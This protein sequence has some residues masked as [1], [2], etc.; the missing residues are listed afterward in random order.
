MPQASQPVNF[1]VTGDGRSE[2][3]YF[4]NV[5]RFIFIILFVVR[6]PL[7]GNAERS[8][9]TLKTDL[10]DR[11]EVFD[12][13][14]GSF[15]KMTVYERSKSVS[16]NLK[17]SEL[18]GHQLAIQ[19]KGTN[20]L[21]I[22]KKGVTVFNDMIIMDLDSLSGI[23]TLQIYTFTLYNQNWIYGNRLST[24]LTTPTLNTADDSLVRDLGRRHESDFTEFFTIS[25][26]ILLT[27]IAILINRFPKES[28]EYSAISYSL[29]FQNREEALI[30]ARPFNR[31]NF[32]FLGLDALLIGFFISSLKVLAPQH[33]EMNFLR[34]APSSYY[35]DWLEISL[36]VFLLLIGKYFLISAFNRLYH[37]GE[38]RFVQFNNSLRYSIWVFLLVFII[39]VLSYLSFRQPHLHVYSFLIN[40]VVFLL[41]IRLFILFFK[42]MNYSDYKNFHLFS[43]LCATEIIPFLVLYKMALG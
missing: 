9:D 40:M 43:Y 24:T 28:N 27:I 7:P 10:S 8:Q 35:I 25:S 41:I 6:L 4:S 1:P 34:G 11:W 39:L 30:T 29:N 36:V 15:R 26:L 13:K 5:F 32:P 18:T 38:F 33:I 2:I 19:S 37:L 22:N 23:S 21:L 20:T 12:F 42:L 16:W 14:A 17:A 3:L 31:N